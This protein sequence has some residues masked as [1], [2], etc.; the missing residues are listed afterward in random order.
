MIITGGI[1]EKDGKFLLVQEAQEKV[2]GKWNIPAG[3]LDFNE[4][5]FEGAKREIYEETGCKVELTGI[6]CIGNYDWII[7][8]TETYINKTEVN[9]Y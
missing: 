5:I 2:Y 8:C 7:D 1:I 3:L 4:T 6:L 9:K